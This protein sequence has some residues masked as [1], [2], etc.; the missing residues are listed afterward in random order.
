MDSRSLLREVGAL[1]EK[2]RREQAKRQQLLAHTKECQSLQAEAEGRISELLY[3]NSKLER[4]AA[5]A[6]EDARAASRAQLHS[7]QQRVAA[8]EAA[9]RARE[10]AVS[11]RLRR[12]RQLVRELGTLV[13]AAAAAQP[14]LS[15]LSQVRR[16]SPSAQP[17]LALLHPR[18]RTARARAPL[19]PAGPG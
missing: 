9:S 19:R 11:E 5:D 6:K 1:K 2:L 15:R 4:D 3:V 7:L 18:K 14:V 10:D 13:P 17:R 16:S 8:V 12:A